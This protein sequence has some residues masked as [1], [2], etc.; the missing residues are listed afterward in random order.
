MVAGVV[1]KVLVALW[2]LVWGF[3]LVCWCLLLLLQSTG[4]NDWC[5]EPP[6]GYAPEAGTQW[7][8][9]PPGLA[10]TFPS[11]DPLHERPV[12]DSPGW[13]APLLAVGGAVPLIVTLSI[14]SRQRQARQAAR[15]RSRAA[16][17]PGSAKTQ[18]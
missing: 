16:P 17:A 12:T 15:A 10:C 7:Q 18:A 3:G 6:S 14:E 13:T 2:S 4:D 5:S 1:A 11:R 8:W 9:L